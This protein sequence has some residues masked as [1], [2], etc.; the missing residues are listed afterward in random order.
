MGWGRRSSLDRSWGCNGGP[1]VSLESLW[2]LGDVVLRT[3][4]ENMDMQLTDL[5]LATSDSCS[6]SAFLVFCFMAVKALALV[7]FNFFFASLS[8]STLWTVVSKFR[9]I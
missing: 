7:A 9:S 5:N 4:S 6:L 3:D 1:K 2:I 8:E